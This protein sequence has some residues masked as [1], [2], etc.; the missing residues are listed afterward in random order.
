MATSNHNMSDLAHHWDIL[1]ARAKACDEFMRTNHMV[2]RLQR[3][4]QIVDKADEREDFNEVGRRF[5]RL[6]DEIR[7]VNNLRQGV[8]PPP[9]RRTSWSPEPFI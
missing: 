4:R 1:L 7:S 2:T 9:P 3:I 6:M 5:D 8:K